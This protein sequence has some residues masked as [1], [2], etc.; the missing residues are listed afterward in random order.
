MLAGLF[1]LVS[2]A[3]AVSGPSAP[4]RYRIEVRAKQEVDLSAMGQGTQTQE[5]GAVGFLTVTMSDTTGGQLAHIVVDSVAV[6]SGIELPA[7]FT[8]DSAA[9]IFFHAYIVNGK[10]QGSLKP[11]APQ[12][13]VGLLAGGIENLFPGMRATAKLGDTWAD[14]VKS[15]SNAEGNSQKSVTMLDWKVT[16]G[17]AGMFTYEAT[18]VGTLMREGPG[19]AGKQTINAKITG[20]RK[21]SGPAAGPMHEGTIKAMQDLLLSM[22]GQPDTIPI[23]ATTEVKF[24]KLP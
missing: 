1:A 9:G 2:L 4:Q 11:S 6:P 20:T 14:T 7:G 3:G 24:V 15:E 23:T 10:V 17:T 5:F 18:T 16:G 19:P 22:E 8:T 13:M 21:V 12:Q